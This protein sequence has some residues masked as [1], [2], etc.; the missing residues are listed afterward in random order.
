[1]PSLPSSSYSRLYEEA[2]P[3]GARPGDIRDPA[4]D[5]CPLYHAL[6]QIDLRYS[7]EELLGTGGMKEVFRIYDERT[8]RHVAL[9]RPKKGVMPERYDA[10]LREAHLTARL[11]HPNIINLF[12]MGIDDQQRPFFTMEFK[13]GLSLRKIL[14][15]L[16]EGAGEVDYPYEQRLSIF[17]RVCEAMAYAHSRHVLHLDLKPENIQVGPFGEVQVCDWGMGEIEQGDSETH[18]S[19]SLLDPDLYGGQ[20]EPAVK[21]TPGYMPPE[22]ETPEAP[23]TVQNDIFALGCLLYELVSLK[24]ATRRGDHPPRSHAVEAIVNKACATDLEERYASVEAMRQDVSR[25]LMGFSPDAEQAGFFREARLFY[26]RNRMPCLITFAS[27]LLLLGAGI[28]FTQQLSKSNRATTSALGQ[29]RDALA[30]AE[31]ERVSAQAA[32]ARAEEALQRYKRERDYAAVLY[33][34]RDEPP[35]KRATF[36]IHTL[37]MQESISLPVIENALLEID[38]EIAKNPPPGDRIWALKGHVLFM[39]Q[40]FE[41]AEEFYAME[42]GDQD[43]LRSLI[44]E[45]AP[46]VREDGLLPVEDFIRLIGKLAKAPLRDRQPLTEKMLIYDSLKRGSPEDTSRLVEV[47]LRTSNPRWTA[48]VFDYNPDTRHLRI[49]GDKLRSLYRRGG[50]RESKEIPVRSLL[51]LLPLDSLDLRGTRLYSFWHLSGADFRTLD[52]RGHPPRNL[53]ALSNIP[54]LRELIVTPGQFAEEQI[55]ALPDK[56][57]VHQ[58]PLKSE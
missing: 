16:R 57:T 29:A 17:L 25:H 11:E 14:S 12:D 9:A 26:R 50:R 13:R 36:L 34:A 35:L 32:Q 4:E 3:S 49:T 24:G 40:R 53:D 41:E 31:S 54:S 37:M 55:G 42:T 5:L 28:W 8:E 10:F 21:G 39:T 18:L 48:G 46:L 15:T 22:Q 58:R 30:I 51:R 7:G 23:K 20:L 52:I 6:R 27:A 43:Y 44:P 33:A 1:M 56:I 19:E 2:D 47:M 45:F 38:R